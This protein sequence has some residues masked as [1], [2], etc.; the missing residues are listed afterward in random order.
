M[1]A[2]KKAKMR[3]ERRIGRNEVEHEYKGEDCN[4]NDGEDL[5]KSS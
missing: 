3:E 1:K 2:E 5:E 4:K